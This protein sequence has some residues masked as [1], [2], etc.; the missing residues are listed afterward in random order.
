MKAAYLDSSCLVAVAFDEGG[1][2]SLAR[3]LE[4]YDLLLSSNLLEAEVR[5]ALAREEAGSDT[6][7]LSWVSWVLPERPLSPEFTTVLSAGRLRGADLWHLSCALYL[8]GT[9][10]EL[11]FLTLDAR[12]EEVARRLGFPAE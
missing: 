5:S 12:Q 6:E 3:R 11:P 10:R 7:L 4:G 2:P 9:P 1:A 8:A